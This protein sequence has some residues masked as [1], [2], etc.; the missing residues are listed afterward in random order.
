MLLYWL[1]FVAL[2][3]E[4]FEKL[5]SRKLRIDSTAGDWE[6]YNLQV[7]DYLSISRISEG[8]ISPSEASRLVGLHGDKHSG[9]DFAVRFE[10]GELCV[11]LFLKVWTR[12]VRRASTHHCHSPSVVVWGVGGHFGPK[13]CHFASITYGSSPAPRYCASG[14]YHT[15]W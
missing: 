7:L 9:Q 11:N 2:T 1:E 15:D 6:T 10:A 13:K 4:L 5:P 3:D 8:T 12:L 14:A